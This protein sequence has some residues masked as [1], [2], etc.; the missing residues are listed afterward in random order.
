MSLGL[1]LTW[2]RLGSG[3]HS[4]ILNILTRTLLQGRIYRRGEDWK[5]TKRQFIRTFSLDMWSKSITLTCDLIPDQLAALQLSNAGEEGAQLLLRHRLRQV[6][7]NEVGLGLQLLR[8]LLC[9]GRRSVWVSVLRIHFVRHAQLASHRL[10]DE[11]V[12]LVLFLSC[13]GFI[14]SL[15]MT[16]Q[17]S[18]LYKRWRISGKNRRKHFELRH[19]GEG[20]EKKGTRGLVKNI[21]CK[22]LKHY[23][24]LIKS[25]PRAMVFFVS[26]FVT[27]MMRSKV[28]K[29]CNWTGHSVQSLSQIKGGGRRQGRLIE[30]EN[31]N[32]C[33]VVGGQRE[34]GA[35][36]ISSTLA[37]VEEK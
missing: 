22:Y 17:L 33:N 30:G 25:L 1:S 12:C 37:A 18:Q 10:R 16:G 31:K 26:Y 9:T 8:G 36:I 27:T 13:P 32:A 23:I 5:A 6:V 34:K 15:V 29:I 28:A 3:L 35:S 4:L 21:C 11:W 24:M 19:S 2:G 7:D 20:E 14:L